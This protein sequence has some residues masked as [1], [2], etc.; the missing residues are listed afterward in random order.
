MTNLLYQFL[1]ISLD[2]LAQLLTI[3]ST[4]GIL[5]KALHIDMVSEKMCTLCCNLKE[6][7]TKPSSW[8]YGKYPKFYSNV[9]L[10]PRYYK[11]IQYP[12]I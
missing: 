1:N 3:S 4:T 2:H 12:K 9:L 6:N 11:Y 7:F 10:G 8:S 5:K